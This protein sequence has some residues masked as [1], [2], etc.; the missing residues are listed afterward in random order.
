M[1]RTVAQIA[2]YY[3]QGDNIPEP[4]LNRVEHGIRCYDPCLSCSTHAAGQMPM[5]IQL[6]GPRGDVRREIVRG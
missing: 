5:R 1:N 4:V 2:R 3:V 6:I